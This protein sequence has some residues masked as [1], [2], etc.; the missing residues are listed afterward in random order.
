[1]NQFDYVNDINQNKKD[2]ISNSENPELMEKEY[3]AFFINKALSYYPDTILYSNEMN[4]HHFVDNKMQF[5]YFLNSIRIKKRFSKWVKKVDNDHL[6]VV[7]EYFGY[8][9]VKAEQALRIL[10]KDQIANIKLR[11]EKGGV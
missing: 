8:N 5:D 2:I 3:S 10:T 4:T 7:K 1:M 9:N 11:L 6:E